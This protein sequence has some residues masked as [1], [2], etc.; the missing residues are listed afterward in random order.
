MVKYWI[1]QLSHTITSSSEYFW[2]APG[3]NANRKTIVCPA[4]N[5]K[6]A[7]WIWNSPRSNDPGL[8]TVCKDIHIYPNYMA[9]NC[10]IFNIL[11]SKGSLNLGVMIRSWPILDRDKNRSAISVTSQ[12]CRR[13][14]KVWSRMT[15][16]LLSLCMQYLSV[17]NK[18]TRC[19]AGVSTIHRRLDDA[20][21]T[22]WKT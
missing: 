18:Q 7:G 17:F 3:E 2:S 21:T 19:D 15:Y 13:S 20:F 5:S 14:K 16:S 11:C 6:T 10:L 8:T 1:W 12:H 4:S 22:N 9:T